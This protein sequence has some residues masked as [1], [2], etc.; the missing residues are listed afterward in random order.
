MVA[1]ESLDLSYN[2]LGGR[3]PSELTKLTFLAVLNLSQN[4]FF[5]PIPVG[6]QFNTFDID[7]YAGNLDF[8]GFPLSKK[9]GS[10]E[11]R[12]PQTPK[13][14]EDEDSSIPF[15]WKL[16]MMGYGCGVVFG[17]STGYIVFTTG[18]PWWLVRMVERDWQ[19]NFTRWVRRIG[20]KRNYHFI[21]IAQLNLR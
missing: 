6:S 8:C 20:R 15:I 16:V 21:Q 9:C 7:S 17:L 10:E 4:N 13:L 11:E 1:L 14:V 2:K 19:R 18:R 12:K 3:I 5:G